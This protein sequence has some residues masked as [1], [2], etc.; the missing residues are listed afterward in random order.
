[1][2]TW[3]TYSFS[4][5][6]FVERLKTS[7][8]GSGLEFQ[9]MDHELLPGDN[10][11]DTIYQSISEADII[12][13]ILSKEGVDR[14]WFST[15]LGILISEIRN[16]PSK[17]IFPVLVDRDV[18]LPPFID[19]YQFLDLSDNKNFDLNIE[20][21][22]KALEQPKKRQLLTEERDIQI[23][24]VIRSKHEMLERE[25]EYYDKKNKEKQKIIYLTT[26]MTVL[27]TFITLF[28]F[29]LSNK[30]IFK[31]ENENL[32]YTFMLVMIGAF[33]GAVISL[34]LNR[35]KDKKDG[36]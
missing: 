7:L 10:I 28:V 5:R 32:I 6:E 4:D 24:N 33:T 29:I 27:V 18:I 1:M 23:S 15:E 17:K 31:L 8:K 20:R 19:Q 25:K 34:I 35:L 26:L 30:G 21:L 13:V 9:D 36:K 2:K 3:I 22:K 16:N 11:V 14:K 12:F